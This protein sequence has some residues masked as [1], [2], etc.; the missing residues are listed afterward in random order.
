VTVLF[1]DLAGF[2]AFAEQRDPEEIHAV[3]ERCF[4]MIATEVHRFEGTINQYTGDGV[5]ALF[6]APIAHEDAPRRAVHAALA[7]QDGV[8][9]LSGEL[10]SRLGR[11]LEMRIGL[12][13]GALIAG[14]LGTRKFVYDVWGDTV[15][16]AKRMESYGLPG[17]VHVS[18]ATPCWAGIPKRSTSAGCR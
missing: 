11:S 6:G 17:Q 3:V 4:E 5:M 9:D 8:R 13:T 18:A 15:N 16:T 10:A 2:S 14:V 12:N 7:I 1:A